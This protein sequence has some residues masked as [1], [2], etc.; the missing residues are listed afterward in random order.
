MNLTQTRTGIQIG[1]LH[2]RQAPRPDADAV[3]V[4]R[5]LLEPR[6]RQQRPALL[7]ILGAVCRWL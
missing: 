1:V 3:Q 2:R 5:A 7:R 6:T 4:Q